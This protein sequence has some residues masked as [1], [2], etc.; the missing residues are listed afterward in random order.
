M[1]E[2]IINGGKTL[3]GNI[4]IG[5][6]KNS[7]VAL[8][9]AALLSSDICNINK[10]PNIS[11]K[12]AL[13][14]ILN[15]LNVKTNFENTSVTIDSTNLKNTIIPEDLS[16]KLRASYYF[17][18]VLLAKF[19]HVE[20][21]FPGGCNIGTRPIDLHLKGFEALGAKISHNE[22]THIYTLDAQE[23]IGT[24]IKLDFASVGATINIMFAA[25][26]ASGT[27]ILENA[28]KEIEIINIADFLN[29]MGAKIKGAGTSTITIEGV[30]KLKGAT[31]DV[32]PDRI[33]AGTYLM[34]GAMIG[35]NLSVC[36]IE[37]SQLKALFDK[38][39]DMGIKYKISDDKVTISKCNNILPINIKTLVYP[40]F[41]TDLGQ[42]ISVL[43][44]QANGTSYFEETIWENR[45]QHVKYLNMM[46]ANIKLQ[47]NTHS[48]INGP[49]KLKG[50]HINA[51]DLRGGAALVMA[52]LIAEG[53]TTIS[54]IEYI[55]RGYE[56]LINKLSK[57]GAD[58]KIIDV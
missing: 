43:L 50:C 48:I 18:G 9:P 56:N 5:G 4:S 51:T 23:L 13:I 34:I 22:K 14:D 31:I 39:D 42:P 58:I 16:Q 29:N 36:G 1:K 30:K 8:I 54:N 6:A 40:G 44:T 45:M 10:V 46:G 35:D 19:K 37:P 26:L 28:A 33:E 11:D 20:M 24:R 3:S 55:L 2:I 41:P 15:I 32:I 53:T 38:F 27:T 47:D 17:M 12:D 49:T 52:G 21:Y 25:C 57:V 7:V